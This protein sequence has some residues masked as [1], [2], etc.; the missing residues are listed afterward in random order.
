[1]R[2]SKS[3]SQFRIKKLITSGV[4]LY[5]HKVENFLKKLED[6]EIRTE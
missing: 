5:Q 2:F 6:G 4:G 1:M 3:A